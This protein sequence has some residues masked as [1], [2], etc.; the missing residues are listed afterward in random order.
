MAMR[1]LRWL[2]LVALC[3]GTVFQTT[4]CETL[5]AP[6]LASMASTLVYSALNSVFLGT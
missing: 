5:V 3:G 2:A 6:L 4:S 1:R